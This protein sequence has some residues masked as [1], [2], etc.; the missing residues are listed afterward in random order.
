[1]II[2]KIV[3]NGQTES[4][5][6]FISVNNP[7]LTS[8]EFTYC[9]D[10]SAKFNWSVWFKTDRNNKR[11]TNREDWTSSEAFKKGYLYVCTIQDFLNGLKANAAKHKGEV[12]H[13]RIT[14]ITEW[15]L[16]KNIS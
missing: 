5:A 10:Q 12:L 16:L 1:M 13:T 11:T 14:T 9:Q 6:V 7:Y 8:K 2:Y 3:I 15:Q 4:G